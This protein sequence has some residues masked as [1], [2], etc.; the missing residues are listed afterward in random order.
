MIET[1]TV[2]SKYL[3]MFYRKFFD[4]TLKNLKKWITLL[5]CIFQ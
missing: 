1:V 5:Y 2:K 4:E 3:D